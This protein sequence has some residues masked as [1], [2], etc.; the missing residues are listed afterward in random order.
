MSFIAAAP[1][2]PEPE[3]PHHPFWPAIAPADFREVMNCDGTVTTPRLTFALTE[4]VTLVNA[5]LKAF[6]EWNS[7]NGAATL[8][9]V[10]DDEPGRL[11]HL[12]RRAVYERTKADLME[13]MIGVS[14]T[15][16][17]QKRAESQDPAIGDHY[18]N[19]LWAIRD[20]IGERRTTV[21]LI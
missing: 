17:G 18:R 16:D 12:Y 1:T 2:P 20:I 3:L 8:A 19:A 11:V 21:E 4:A 13:R 10:P 14:A 9:D 5:A 7:A 6:R 15:A